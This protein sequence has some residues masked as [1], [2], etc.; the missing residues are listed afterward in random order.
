M[1]KKDNFDFETESN[2]KPSLNFDFLK[3]LTKQQKGIIL[4]AIVSVV[5]VVA[6]VV[7]FVI[8]GENSKS[9]DSN[10]GGASNEG[11]NHE[12][13]SSSDGDD[14]DNDYGDV[15]LDASPVEIYVSA[16]PDKTVF[17]KGDAPNYSGLVI[18]VVEKDSS[19]FKISYDDYPDELV[20]TGFDSSK[21]I[22]EQTITV[23]YKEYTTTFTIRIREAE[24]GATLVAIR[25]D[26]LPNKTTYKLGE[27]LS[28]TGGR[29]VCE[30]SDG[31]TK[32]LRFKDEGV[33][34]SGFATITS[35]GEYDIKVEYFDDKG[36]YA[37]TTFKIT[38]EQ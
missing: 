24:I 9:S 18:G 11:G 22:D 37:W 7:V 2:G 15:D 4:A 34:I 5:L 14:Y 36:G 38:M 28:Y 12:G 6:I 17:D 8:I 29:V 20:I 35:P 19:G 33:Q 21:A 26:P 16:L 31:T 10:G 30:Y 1:A 25:V 27:A 13:G 3:N 23:Q 32:T